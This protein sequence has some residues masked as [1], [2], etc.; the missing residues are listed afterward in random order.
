MSRTAQPWEGASPRY[1][2]DDAR[3]RLYGDG[4]GARLRR[5]HLGRDFPSNIVR[6]HDLGRCISF[7]LLLQSATWFLFFHS[8]TSMGTEETRTRGRV[9]SHTCEPCALLST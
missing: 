9:I 8:L 4:E 7:R 6:T 3:S 2:G 1:G 5:R